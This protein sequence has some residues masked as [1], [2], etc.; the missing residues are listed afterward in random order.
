MIPLADVDIK[1]IVKERAE[2]LLSLDVDRCIA[3][4]KK[5]NPDRLLPPRRVIE[6][7][8]HKART[9]ALSLPKEERKKSKRWLREHDMDTMPIDDGDLD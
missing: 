8:M 6:A 5:Y 2:M 3:F 4:Y 1:A 9:G 7:G